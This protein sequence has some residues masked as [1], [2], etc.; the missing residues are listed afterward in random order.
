MNVFSQSLSTLSDL[1]RLKIE[2]GQQ[3][4]WLVSFTKQDIYCFYLMLRS[5]HNEHCPDLQDNT[6]LNH[7]EVKDFI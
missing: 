2:T 5:S 1:Y 4:V 3:Y 7:V 6:V